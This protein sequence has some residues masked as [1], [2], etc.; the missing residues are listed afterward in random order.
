M[1]EISSGHFKIYSSHPIPGGTE[2]FPA[3]HRRAGRNPVVEYGYDLH[4][5]PFIPIG[6]PTGTVLKLRSFR[7]KGG[8]DFNR[9]DFKTAERI[10]FEYKTQEHIHRAMADARLLAILAS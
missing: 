4:I 8:P 9:L 10:Y 7:R 5:E 2:T 1:C 6:H 3:T